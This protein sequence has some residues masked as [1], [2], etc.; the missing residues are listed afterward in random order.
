VRIGLVMGRYAPTDKSHMPEV[1]RL[2]AEW[3]ATAEP[4][5]LGDELIDLARIRVDYDLYVLKDKSDLA[6]RVA[7]ALHSAGAAL[8]NPYPASATLRDRIV[9]L[10]VLQAAGV[11]APKTFVASHVDQLRA[12]LEHGPLVIK[13]YRKLA[14][15]VPGEGI[16]VVRDPAELAALPPISEPVFAQRYHAS[17][18]P[19]RKIYSIGTEIFGVLRGWPARTHREKLGQA[20]APDAELVDI[21]R[22]CGAALG[23]DLFGVTV[24]QSGGK[25]YVVDMT[26]IPGFKGVPDAP[27]RLAEYIYAA[28]ERAL[29]GAP[30]V[31][32]VPTPVRDEPAVRPPVV[33][34]APPARRPISASQALRPRV[35]MYSQGMVGF[36]H[37]RRNASIAQALRGSPLQP[38]IVLIA[39][40]WQAG[41]LP[42]PPGVDCVTLPALR[43]EVDGGYNPRFLSDVSDR[44]LISLRARVIRSAIKTFVPDV[45]VV[46]CLP[47]GVAGELTRTLARLRKGGNTRCVLGLRDV[48][49]DAETVRRD[50]SERAHMDAIRD[51]YD[52]IW[53]Y[54]DPAVYDP[55]REYAL[56]DYAAAKVRYTGYLD[57]RPRLELAEAQTAGL[58]ASLP[59]GKVVLCV[60]GGGHDGGAL[61][62]AFVAADFPPDTTGVVVTGPLMPWETRQRLHR[63]AQRRTRLELLE[64][65]PDP[66]PLIERADRVIAMGGYNTVCEV[67]SFGKHALIVPRVTEPEQGIR[68][69]RMQELG[70]V[71]LLHPDDLSPQA[72]SDWLARDAG[73]LPATGGRVDLG[74][75]T[76]IPCLLAELLGVPAGPLQPAAPAAAEVGLT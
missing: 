67:L 25:P 45:L 39:E 59:P 23:I 40:A 19:D 18:G 68:A 43:R 49:Q 54:G 72:L 37:I 58:L 4:V 6:M 26:S 33:R 44:D 28:T 21:T 71:D 7:A 14:R 41:A 42:M 36:G 24:V 30:L 65:V 32:G 47:V 70:L 73:P 17:D 20:F 53:V 64:F 75:L 74:G 62:E 66:V 76:R 61:A 69:R 12:A 35:A 34:A 55:V 9:K 13:P 5:H 8:L 63:A 22:R 31:S 27:R 38:S 51:Y 29:S 2:L 48:L 50:W 52:A 57:Q 10:R 15:G 1:V 11:P 56:P 60:V 46:D 3:G 16:H